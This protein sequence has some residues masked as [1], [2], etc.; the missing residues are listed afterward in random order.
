[1]NAIE[2][3]PTTAR[4]HVSYRPARGGTGVTMLT[5]YIVLLFAFPSNLQFTALGSLGKPA[6]LWGVGLLVWWALSHM[7]PS[8]AATRVRGRAMR[9]FLVLFCAVVLVSY[10]TGVLRGQP[11]DQI[12]SA[13]SSLVRITSWSGVCLLAIDGVRTRDDLV[14]LFR[15]LSIAAG[16]LA[17]LGLAQIATGSSL[18]D[19]TGS[20]PGW[21]IEWS[22]MDSRGGTTRAV[23]TSTHPLE[24]SST[25]TALLPVSIAHAVIALQSGAPG[26]RRWIIPPAGVLALLS[27][28]VTR[29]AMIG[30]VVALL[31]LLPF[32][33][34]RFRNWLLSLGVLGAGAVA[35]LFP[36]IVRATLAA[37]TT[38]ADDPSALSRANALARVP[39][40]TAASPIVGA[41]WGTFLP[42]YY[43]FDNAWVLMLVE[44][45]IAGVAMFVLMVLS[46]IFAAFRSASRSTTVDQRVLAAGL[47]AAVTAAAVQMALF[48]G[49]AFGQFAGTLFLLLGCGVAVSG[50]G[51]ANAVGAPARRRSS[52]A[53][54]GAFAAPPRT[55]S[56]ARRDDIG[57]T[58][59]ASDAWERS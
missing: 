8:E 53:L 45:G 40:F 35:V 54:L 25:M 39:E 17:V 23:G 3:S 41:G 48:D 18:L 38:V 6:T 55:T 22:V 27:I 21:Q 12:G 7:Q 42:R 20:I 34:R 33:P 44:V 24:F 30:T 56:S 32:L 46:G 15:R 43:I 31:L 47:A 58:E 19:W 28:T 5:V 13:T 57:L 36:R 9:T 14:T 1:M 37:F 4:R 51:G 16:L 2:L 59:L 52:L 26:A 49:M 50:I 29:S 11:A 10:A